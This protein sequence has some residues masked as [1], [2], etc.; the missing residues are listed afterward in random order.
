MYRVPF[1][2]EAQRLPIQASALG[3]A[4]ETNLRA[5]WPRPMCCWRIKFFSTPL[6]TLLPTFQQR[7]RKEEAQYKKTRP[8]LSLPPLFMVLASLYDH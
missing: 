7:A 3:G 4:L 8:S 6:L 1:S 2:I 5:L